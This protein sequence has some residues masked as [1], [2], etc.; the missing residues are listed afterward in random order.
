AEPLSP[1]GWL[2]RSASSLRY[3]IQSLSVGEPS[4]PMSALR[5]RGTSLECVPMLLG[6]LF[7]IRKP[8]SR[9]VY[10]AW[11]AGRLGHARTMRPSATRIVVTR[12]QRAHRS[13]AP[14]SDALGGV[15]Q[16][17]LQQPQWRHALV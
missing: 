8:L 5:L 13:I 2:G 10:A 1:P 6:P 11:P 3:R 16:C 9:Y 17:V 4:P 12:L 15:N 7:P 14:S